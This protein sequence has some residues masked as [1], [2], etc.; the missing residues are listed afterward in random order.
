[1]EGKDREPGQDY[2]TIILFDNQKTAINKTFTVTIDVTQEKFT[3]TAFIPF[4]NNDYWEK[5]YSKFNMNP[6]IIISSGTGRDKEAHIVKFPPTSKMNFSYFGTD[7]DVSKPDEGLYYV[8]SENMPTGLQISGVRVGTK[9]SADFLVPI[10]KTSILEAY[11]KFGAWAS[12][13]GASNGYWWKDPDNSK[14]IT[15]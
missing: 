14:V 3:E 7:S 2:P 11:P 10:E 15:Q 12:S 5:T 13:F 6:F 1:M 8:N 9:R 4:F